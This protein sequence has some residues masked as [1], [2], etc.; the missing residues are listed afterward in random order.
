MA[1]WT[2]RGVQFSI[3]EPAMSIAAA[4]PA[5]RIDVRSGHT[6]AIPVVRELP[7]PAPALDAGW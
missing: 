6:Y 2:L 7:R 4:Q 5:R 1:E 3:Q